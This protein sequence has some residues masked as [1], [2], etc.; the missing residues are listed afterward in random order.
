M[1]TEIPKHVNLHSY[2]VQTAKEMEQEAKRIFP[3]MNGAILCAAVSD[4]RPLS[5]S[6]QKLKSEDEVSEITL[7][8]TEDI[9]SALGQEKKNNQ[10]LAG[11]ALETN[12]I[13]ENARK[14]RKKKNFDF[15][16]LN[17]TNS[18]ES[19]FGADENK[20]WI[21]SK[22]KDMVSIPMSSKTRIAHDILSQVVLLTDSKENK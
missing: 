18:K 19:P 8:K 1:S 3:K 5:Y 13:F 17:T 2:P 22:D 21:I 12:D 4:Y 9:A 16:V 6:D 14:K 7:E 11:F 20:V 15:I 10:W